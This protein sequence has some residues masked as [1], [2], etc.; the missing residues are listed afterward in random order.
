MHTKKIDVCDSCYAIGADLADGMAF[1]LENWEGDDR[2][3]THGHCE[4]EF[5]GSAPATIKNISVITGKGDQLHAV[6]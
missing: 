2:W 1:V 4:G 3:I 5:P 6:C